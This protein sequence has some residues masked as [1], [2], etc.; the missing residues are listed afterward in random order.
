MLSSLIFLSLRQLD[1]EPSA[2][3]EMDM[4]CSH[5]MLGTGQLQNKSWDSVKTLNFISCHVITCTHILKEEKPHILE[6][7][8]LFRFN[9]LHVDC[10][11]NGIYRNLSNLRRKFSPVR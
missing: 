5:F 6:F 11:N 3:W 10:S 2:Q 8:W 7:I 1:D 4:V 9:P